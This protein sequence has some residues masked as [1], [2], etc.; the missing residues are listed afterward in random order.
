MVDFDLPENSRFRQ[1]S[2]F[3][4]GPDNDRQLLMATAATAAAD[5]CSYRIHSSDISVHTACGQPHA[6]RLTCGRWDVCLFR[7]AV[8]FRSTCS[9]CFI[10]VLVFALTYVFRHCF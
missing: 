1:M 10:A 6:G 2:R 7:S 9:F 8:P 5:A 3:R 4:A